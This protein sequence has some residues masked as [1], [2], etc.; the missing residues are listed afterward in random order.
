MGGVVLPLLRRTAM[1]PAVLQSDE[2]VGEFLRDYEDHVWELTRIATNFPVADP[3]GV[4]PFPDPFRLRL[5]A[6]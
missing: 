1:G 6:V 3:C 2:H 5:T 4:L